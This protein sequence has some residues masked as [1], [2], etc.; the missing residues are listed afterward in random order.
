[1]YAIITLAI[2][3]LLIVLLKIAINKNIITKPNFIL[4]IMS[5]AICVLGIIRYF[6][7][8]AFVETV[9]GMSDPLQSFLRWGYH[10]GYAI[11]PMSVFFN[12]RLIRNIATCFTLP[13]T[14]L[15][16]IFI[17][18]TFVYFTAAGAGG[19]YV[20]EWFRYVTYILELTLSLVTIVLMQMHTKHCIDIKN[21]KEVFLTVGMIPLIMLQMMPS[22]I[23]QSIISDFS[24]T[25]EMFGE[26]HL[27][28]LFSLTAETVLLHYIFRKR[29]EE[30]KYMLLVF[31]VIAQVMHTTSPMLRGFTFSRLPLQ[32][33]NIAAF[34]YLYM[35]I[36]KD[37]KV[38]DFCYLAN[39]V[40][41]AIAMIL[42]SFS[43]DTLSF[44]NIHYIYE[45]S[46]V[47]MVPVLSTT[48]GLF[49]RLD[50][51]ALKSMMKYFTA[52]FI[53]IFLFGTIVNGVNTTPDPFPVNHFYMFNPTVAI[54]YL[55]FVGFI[56]A[57]HWEFGGFEI[58]PILVVTIFVVFTALN[59]LFYFITRGSYRL[60]DSIKEKAKVKEPALQAK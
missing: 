33:C 46:F 10:I 56:N 37:K 4:K 30:D 11:I 6:L 3:I 42:T 16:I 60:I 22:Y 8:D 24:L 17:E 47:V 53:F 25:A 51:A 57:V 23:P 21:F 9:F 2:S 5:V 44:W 1:M 52:Y 7:S 12:S 13:V 36:K 40:G 49:P 19:F 55:P 43:S 48:L 31:L 35:I 26:L 29:S 28:W 54:E 58:Y 50:K 41:A 34:F 14:M 15:C 18:D 38:F 27:L 20:D 45:H 32:L 39:L 59:F